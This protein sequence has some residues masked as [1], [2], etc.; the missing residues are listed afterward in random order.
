M[1]R[2]IPSRTGGRGVARLRRAAG[3][4][5][6]LI[7]ASGAREQE[8]GT[9]SDVEPDR[10]VYIRSALAAVARVN[11]LITVEICHEQT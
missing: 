11:L 2:L 4:Q 8:T 7:G 3:T 1:S 10:R 5:R 6:E 9:A